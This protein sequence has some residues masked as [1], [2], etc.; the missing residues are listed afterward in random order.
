[1]IFALCY[2]PKLCSMDNHVS[3]RI[4][5]GSAVERSVQ[6]PRSKVRYYTLPG[7]CIKICGLKSP[8]EQTGACPVT[9]KCSRFRAI[10]KCVRCGVQGHNGQSWGATLVTTLQHR[11]A[12]RGFDQSQTY[13]TISTSNLQSNLQTPQALAQGLGPFRGATSLLPWGSPSR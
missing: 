5:M 9:L 2:S 7:F 1:M 11:Q 6:H 3:R 13:N 10:C 4:F 12:A 8:V